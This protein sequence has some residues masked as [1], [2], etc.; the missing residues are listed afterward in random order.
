MRY[1]FNTT[2]CRYWFYYSVNSLSASFIDKFIFQYFMFVSSAMSGAAVSAHASLTAMSYCCYVQ[3]WHVSEQLKMNERM[4]IL[5]MLIQTYNTTV[6]KYIHTIILNFQCNQKG[7][8]YFL[9][10]L[11]CIITWCTLCLKEVPTFKLSVTLSN[12]NRFSKFLHCW[13]AYEICYKTYT[14]IP[15]HLRHVATLPWEIKNS[16]FLHIF[17]RYGRKC[18]QIAF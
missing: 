14:T 10:F 16:N 11:L 8:Y 17:S 2:K 12:L 7:C 6:I 18:K 4:N 1:V 3:C 13:K 5:V 9:W 15:P